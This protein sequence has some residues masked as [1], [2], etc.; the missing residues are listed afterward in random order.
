M[1]IEDNT[2]YDENDILLFISAPIV[3]PYEITT[4]EEN[5][6]IIACEDLGGTYD[7]DFNDL[8]F[9]I[10]L[11]TTTTTTTT[12]GDETGGS[13]ISFSSKVYMLPLAAGGT[14][15]AHIFLSTQDL[16][17]IHALLGGTSASTSTP[18]NV[19]D[20]GITVNLANRDTIWINT[21]ETPYAE[22]EAVLRDIKI[23]VTNDKDGDINANKITFPNKDKQSNIPQMLL[24]PKGWDWPN[25]EIIIYDVYPKFK[26][27]AAD[28]TENGWIEDPVEKGINT[29]YFQVNP[30]K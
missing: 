28:M 1:G 9:E 10:G 18:I 5:S 29:S 19:G 7:Y 8:V 25:E 26:D 20:K 17:E 22:I 23:V 30:F 27:W 21:D 3:P 15:P 2:D 12:S 13:T 4:E 16:G 24:L 14:M 11:K 6:W